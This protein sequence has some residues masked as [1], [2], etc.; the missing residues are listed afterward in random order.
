MVQPP[1]L[2]MTPKVLGFRT[3]TCMTLL[4][5]VEGFEPS[6]TGLEAVVLPL[7]HT[8]PYCLPVFTRQ[9]QYTYRA[10]S[11]VD[12]PTPAYS[13]GVQDARPRSTRAVALGASRRSVSWSWQIV[14]HMVS[15]L[16][17]QLS[18][19]TPIYLRSGS[20]LPERIDCIENFSPVRCT[21]TWFLHSVHVHARS[22]IAAVRSRFSRR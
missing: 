18:A 10:Y 4:A 5:P 6:P 3:F 22:V 1:S 12:T 9:R 11:A 19:A 15:W 21:K 2:R 17:S 14:N 20:M 8:D 13:A 7:H 16:S